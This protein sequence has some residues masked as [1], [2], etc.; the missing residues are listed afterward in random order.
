[1]NLTGKAGANGKRELIAFRIGGQ[2]FCVD[3]MSVREIRGWTMATPLPQ[4]P[5]F[6]RGVINLRGTVLPIVDLASRLGYPA[7]EPT[8]RHAIM[9]AQSGTQIA[10]LLVEGVSD[11]FTVTEEEIQPTPDVASDMA[12]RFVRGVIAMEGRLISIIAI[13]AV[14]PPPEKAAA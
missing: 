1:M 6:V 8:A 13:E 14:L 5:E 4:A 12:K 7:A 11:I 10:G 3:V 2:E 9:V